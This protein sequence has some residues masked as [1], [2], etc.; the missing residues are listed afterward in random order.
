MGGVCLL[1]VV[2]IYGW[3][4]RIALRMLKLPR[5]SVAQKIVNAT[6]AVAPLAIG[7]GPLF[8]LIALIENPMAYVTDAGVMKENVFSQT[9]VSFTWGEIARVTAA[10][11]AMAIH[12][13]SLWSPQ[14]G[15]GSTLEAPAAST[16]VR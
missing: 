12:V 11:R 3:L 7:L 9:P 5:T 16:S 4:P 6:I 10:W 15:A 2:A 8:V 1:F 13:G 14:T